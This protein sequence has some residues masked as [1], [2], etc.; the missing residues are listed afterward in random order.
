MKSSKTMSRFKWKCQA[1]KTLSKK[2]FKFTNNKT[3][4]VYNKIYEELMF[5]K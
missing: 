5:F 4:E 3:K 2:K 1:F